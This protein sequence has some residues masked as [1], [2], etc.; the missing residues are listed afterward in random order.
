MELANKWFKLSTVVPDWCS[1][2][3]A[4]FEGTIL[5][6][7]LCDR[8]GCLPV[9]HFLRPGV[10]SKKDKLKKKKKSYIVTYASFFL[11]YIFP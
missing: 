2:T 9:V 1:E 7:N 8:G 11:R 3:G 6:P 4:G 5:H 10:E